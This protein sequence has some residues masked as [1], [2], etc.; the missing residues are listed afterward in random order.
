M[1][2]LLLHIEEFYQEDRP[3]A[4]ILHAQGHDP[5]VC[6]QVNTLAAVP[7]FDTLKPDFILGNVPFALKQKIPHVDQLYKM[8]GTFGYERTT[9]LLGK[10]LEALNTPASNLL[11]GVI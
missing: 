9:W 3:W 11:K 2:P 10:M 7:V 4:Q 8:N 1:K 5:W 6:H